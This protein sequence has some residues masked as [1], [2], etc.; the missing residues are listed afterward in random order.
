MKV[1]FIIPSLTGGGAERVVANLANKMDELGHEVKILMTASSDVEYSLKKGIVLEQITERTQGSI[2]KRVQRIFLLRK[3]F[4]THPDEAFI[5]MPTETN[6]FAVLASVGLPVNLIISER[7][8][9]H[10]DKCKKLRDLIY[11]LSKKMVFQ[12]KQAEDY[13]LK[14]SNITGKIIANPLCNDKIEI[15]SGDRTKRIVV[16]GRLNHLKNHKMLLQAYAA[17]DKRCKEYHV[18]IY[19]KGELEQELKDL[20]VQLDI[21]GNVH[22]E[23]FCNDIH[24]QIKDAAMYVLSSDAE[25][26][27]NSLLEAMAAG[28]P[29]ISTDCPIGGSAML[30]E[31]MKN[32]I[33]VPVGDAAAMKDA[34]EYMIN[35]REAAEAMGLEATKVRERYS[36]DLITQEWLAYMQE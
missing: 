30:I 29:V 13:Y 7:S 34:M 1:C 14:E 35:N 33:L 17:L 9:P 23:G 12:T 5:A 31:H 25:G 26:M 8:D 3:Y 11:R 20:C 6:M 15:Y 18:Y 10:Q 32:G 28:L 27:S 19:G 36:I 21:V 2:Y 24:N 22:F 4:K 16:V